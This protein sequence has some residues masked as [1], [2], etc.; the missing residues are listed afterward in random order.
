MMEVIITAKHS[1]V[2]YVYK[3]SGEEYVFEA[4]EKAAAVKNDFGLD[5]FRHKNDIYE[6]RTGFRLFLETEIPNLAKIIEANGGLEGFNARIEKQVSKT[7][8]SPRYTRP[9]ERKQ[10]VFPPDPEKEN[11][12]FAK[13]IDGKKHYYNRFYNEN[14]IELYLMK[15][16]SN[17]DFYQSIYVPCEGY[18][19]GVGQYHN[20]HNNL[21]TVLK[22]L[23][24]FENGLKGE[25]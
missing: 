2:F 18:M 14:G 24:G 9:D 17:N 12:V 3:K 6:G 20:Q 22:F 19:V 15:S 25:I 16:K 11:T 5:L 1:N 4:V 21:D 10:D 8:E 23:A 13:G 7:G